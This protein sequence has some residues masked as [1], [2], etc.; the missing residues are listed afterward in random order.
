MKSAP[1]PAAGES[2][3]QLI[4]QLDSAVFDTREAAGTKLAA[5]GVAAIAA[6]EKA[7]ANGNLE[8]S[9]R[10]TNILGGLLKSPDEATEN[11]AFKALQNLAD[12]DS[13]SAARKARSIL[14]KKYGMKNNGQGIVTA[15]GVIMPATPLAGRLSSTAV[16]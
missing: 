1:Q 6:L 4:E 9:S 15:G 14:E 7:A 3:E 5:K 11:T 12:S 10:A 13:A 2:I 16:N 8:V